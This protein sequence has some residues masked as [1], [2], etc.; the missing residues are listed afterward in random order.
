MIGPW[1]CKSKVYESFEN[2][3]AIAAESV[4]NIKKIEYGKKN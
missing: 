1:T 4:K 2:E 3:L